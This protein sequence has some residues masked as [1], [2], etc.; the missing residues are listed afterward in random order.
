M[1]VYPIHILRILHS[2]ELTAAAAA[3]AAAAVL[4][5]ADTVTKNIAGLTAGVVRVTL[6]VLCITITANIFGHDTTSMVTGLGV[7]GIAVGFAL[8]QTISDF[9]AC[10]VILM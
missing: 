3:A 9:F 8:Q 5:S 1:L 2:R 7:S 4:W 6:I 10:V